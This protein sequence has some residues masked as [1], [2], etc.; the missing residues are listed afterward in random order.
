MF[1][2]LCLKGFTA[3]KRCFGLTIGDT[4]AEAAI[5]NDDLYFTAWIYAEFFQW[6]LCNTAA[7]LP[8]R[9]DLNLVK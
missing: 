5:F 9:A 1:E 4:H 7:A 8:S 2:N 3:T 6:W